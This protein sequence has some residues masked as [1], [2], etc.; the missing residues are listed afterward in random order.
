MNTLGEVVA[1]LA[2]AKGE[3]WESVLLL[4]VKPRPF[5][6]PLPVWQRLVNL[7]LIQSENVR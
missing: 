1:R 4:H 7:V 2:W 3:A 5:W 6:C